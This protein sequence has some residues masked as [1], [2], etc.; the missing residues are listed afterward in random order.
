MPPCT[1]SAGAGMLGARGVGAGVYRS[2]PA[3]GGAMDFRDIA[4]VQILRG[5]QGTLFGQNATGGALNFV[6]AKPTKTF[7]AGVDA[8]Y[9]NFNAVDLDPGDHHSIGIFRRNGKPARNSGSIDIV[10]EPQDDPIQPI[11]AIIMK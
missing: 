8:S 6:A 2:S 9:G 4:S 10:V 7:K 11:G 1:S 3:V 5:P